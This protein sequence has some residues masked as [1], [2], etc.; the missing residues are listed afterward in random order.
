MKKNKG[1]TLIELLVVIAIIGILAGIVLVA[2]GGAR[3]R[4]RAARVQADLA[5]I[6]TVAELLFTAVTPNS[7]ATLCSGGTLN[8]SEAN[9]GTQLG[10]LETDITNNGGTNTC[11][12]D[13]ST[14]CVA[15]TLPAAPGNWC[16][17][18]NGRSQSTGAC[19]APA[20]DDCSD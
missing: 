7:Y 2:L 18:S 16:V 5:Q 4:A 11:V 15:S 19:T 12:A 10:Q 3:D 13:A 8:E 17:D 14:F 20:P 6:R 9:Y 1:F